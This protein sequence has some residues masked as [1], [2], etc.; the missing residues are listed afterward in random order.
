MTIIS[1]TQVRER[2]RSADGRLIVNYGG[3]G[4]TIGAR[5]RSA[6]VGNGRRIRETRSRRARVEEL[7]FLL[8][9][10]YSSAGGIVAVSWRRRHT[11]PRTLA[12]A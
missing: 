12:A 4:T 10:Q 11:L 6:P 3:D 8:I 5:R 9:R 2:Y 7:Y 1:T